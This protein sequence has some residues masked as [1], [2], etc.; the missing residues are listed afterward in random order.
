MRK[1]KLNKS[2]LTRVSE[3]FGDALTVNYKHI[4]SVEMQFKRWSDANEIAFNFW[5]GSRD[6]SI[7]GGM[8]DGDKY[9][10]LV[11]FS[12][13]LADGSQDTEQIFEEIKV[14]RSLLNANT[15]I[16]ELKIHEKSKF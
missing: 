11:C 14:L 10:G 6:E 12:F 2:I 5:T 1:A 16:Y 3:L 15:T 4:P 8:I 9:P 7:L 13:Y